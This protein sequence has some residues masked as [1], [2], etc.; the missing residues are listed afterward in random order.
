LKH[1]ASSGLIEIKPHTGAFVARLTIASVVEM[2]EM[3]AFL[4]GACASLAARRH[5]AGDRVAMATAH[6]ACRLAAKKGDPDRFYDANAR[7]HEAIYRASRNGY[8]EKQTLSL[9]NRLEPYRRSITFHAGL[10]EKSMDEHQRVLDAIF[11]MDEAAAQASMGNHVDTLRTDV[12]TMVEAIN[13]PAIARPPARACRPG[14]KRK[15]A[16]RSRG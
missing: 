5:D 7:L 4:E 8:V 11:R 2:F 15:P 3:M 6:D 10:M 1:L 9:R 12:V 14:K 16:A 13:R